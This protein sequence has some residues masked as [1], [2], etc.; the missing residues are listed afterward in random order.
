MKPAEE[1]EKI[2][3][4]IFSTEQR[5]EAIR[6][7]EEERGKGKKVVMQDL[8][9]IGDIDQMTKSFQNVTYFIGARKEEK[10]G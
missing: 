6:F 4:V 10:H 9:G 1:Q 3:V 7:A 8:A 5:K 2:D